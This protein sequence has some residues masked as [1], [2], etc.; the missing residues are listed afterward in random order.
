MFKNKMTTRRGRESTVVPE[1]TRE[2]IFC[3]PQEKDREGETEG[4]EER[5]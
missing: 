3:E 2:L 1:N 4:D 5:Y